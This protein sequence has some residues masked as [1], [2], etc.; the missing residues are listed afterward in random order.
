[1]PILGIN[2]EKCTNCKQCTMD[3]VAICFRWNRQD[4]KVIFNNDHEGC[5]LCGHCIACCPVNAIHYNDMQDVPISIKNAAIPDF[6]TLY[7]LFRSKR[8]I[9]HY[10][11]KPVA[12]EILMKII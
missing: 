10:K 7:S 9:R 5:I 2:E 3:C 6:D 4:E 12:D 8:S 1:M 11:P